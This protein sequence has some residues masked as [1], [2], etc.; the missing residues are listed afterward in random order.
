MIKLYNTLTRKKE[1][2]KSLQKGQVGIYS[3]GPTVYWYAHIGNLRAYIFAD[4]LKRMFLYNKYQVNHVI[5]ITDVGHLTSDSDTGEDKL[6]KGAR[7][8]HKSVWEIA[9]H[10]TQ[11]FKEDIQTLN[12]IPPN[13]FCKATDN[14]PEQ[15][16]LVQVLEKKGFT[17]QIEDGIYFDTS[18]LD[19]YGKLAKLDIKNIKAGARIEMVEGKKNPTDFALWKFS[20]QHSKR[21]MEWDSPWGK[22]F[23]GWHIECSAMSMK[24]LGKHFDIHTGGI[25]H[26]PIHHTNEIAQSESA[27]GEPFVNYWMHNEF[28]LFNNEKMAKSTGKIY[29]LKE[30]QEKEF[31]PVNYRYM[32][33]NTHYRKQMNFTLEGLETAK[34]SFEALKKKILE[35]KKLQE[36]EEK[37]E[38]KE[39]MSKYKE[40]FCETINDDLNMTEALAVLYE[41]L[42]DDKLSAKEKLA[43]S[44]DFD[45]V[46]GLNLKEL[47]EEH[48]EVPPDVM[49]LVNKRENARKTKNYKLSDELRLRIKGLGYEVLDT[50]KGPEVKKI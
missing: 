45:S 8:E 35:L 31:Q 41:A 49:D 11:A 43:V 6:E 12:I 39:L 7:R 50:P 27:T 25:D 37:K 4:L 13:I 34:Q 17:Y 22:G 48:F 18:K 38:N 30:L 36:H 42:K 5:N 44:F 26:I 21:Q 16:A 28:V 47:K 46:L 40:K 15:I 9:E 1:T 10:Y 29:T 3:C 33:L 23:P 24:Y 2:F 14:I 20:P 32:C 19:D